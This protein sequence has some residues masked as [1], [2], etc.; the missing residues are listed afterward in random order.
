VEGR[1]RLITDSPHMLP[2]SSV[3]LV[4]DREQSNRRVDGVGE[5]SL[6]ELGERTVSSQLQ[7]VVHVIPN[8]QQ[9]SSLPAR[10]HGVDEYVNVNL[11]VPKLELAD[12]SSA[13]LGLDLVAKVLQHAPQE[14]GE[15]RA[16]Q[17]VGVQPTVRT[18]TAVGGRRPLLK[19]WRN[20]SISLHQIDVA[21]FK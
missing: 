17:S 6:T 9:G 21:N 19:E 12:N 3:A 20:R 14:S 11:T 18:D 5:V 10:L 15:S 1:S 8:G 4:P 2:P 7:R 13:V 16:V